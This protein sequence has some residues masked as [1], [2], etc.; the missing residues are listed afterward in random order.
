MLLCG[1]RMDFDQ[2]M[3]NLRFHDWLPPERIFLENA[4]LPGSATSAAV[5]CLMI[6]WVTTSATP[7]RVTIR[8]NQR[9]G[10]LLCNLR[11]PMKFPPLPLHTND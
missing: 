10:A 9:T 3:K 5:R 2:A 7:V 8:P 1:V 6:S 11:R 4:G